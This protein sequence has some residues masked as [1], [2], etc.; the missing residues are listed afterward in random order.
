M[1]VCMLMLSVKKLGDST[2]S[3]KPPIIMVAWRDLGEMI[4]ARA[5]VLWPEGAG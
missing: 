3:A 2:V 4:I 5:K 1:S